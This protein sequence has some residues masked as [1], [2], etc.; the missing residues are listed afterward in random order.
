MVSTDHTAHLK[1]LCQRVSASI[2]LY[3]TGK[4]KKMIL[5][6]AMFSQ[7][8]CSNQL[9]H[10]SHYC[11]AL[12]VRTDL[13]CQCGFSIDDENAEFHWNKRFMKCH[14]TANTTYA[15]LDS[16]MCMSYD[17]TTGVIWGYCPYNS[18]TLRTNHKCIGRGFRYVKIPRNPLLINNV[19]CGEINRTGVLCSE[20]MD[21]LSPAVFHYGM[22]CVT[23]LGYTRGWLLYLLLAFLPS[24]FF[25]LL[26]TALQIHVSSSAL[27]SMVLICQIFI[28]YVNWAPARYIV[29]AEPIHSLQ[30]FLLTV[31]GI[32]NLDFFRYLIPPFCINED[33]TALQTV[34]L[35]YLV[36]VYPLLL[37]KVTYILIELHDRDCRV[38]VLMWRP[39]HRCFTH[40]RRQWNPKATIIHAFASFLLL[41]YIKLAVIS[42][43]LLRNNVMRNETLDEVSRSVAY[44]NPSMELFSS[45]HAPYAV[46]SLSILLIFTFLPLVILV[47]YP[48]TLTQRCLS[49]LHVKLYFLREVICSLQGCFKDGTGQAGGRDLRHFASI[50]LSLRISYVVMLVIPSSAGVVVCLSITCVLAF[51]V[52][53]LKPYKEDWCNIWSSIVLTAI[54]ITTGLF[55]FSFAVPA[56]F[57][58]LNIIFCLPLLYMILLVLAVA[59]KKTHLTQKLK[60]IYQ[61]AICDPGTSTSDSEESLPYRLINMESQ[62]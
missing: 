55:S 48:L 35:E 41:S 47:L 18:C 61:R 5:V 36:A 17:E 39:F 37:I 54:V 21:G 50:F 60:Y 49:A 56:S 59:A 28:N 19:M 22:P 42:C 6:L 58:I 32:W 33:L 25:F 57:I 20:C 62:L 10:S 9:H 27:D 43:T 26:L 1:N 7:A 29:E 23:C 38:L 15:S 40:F 16:A 3:L 44:V 12:F 11:P 14:F 31:Y 24:T 2:S 45:G 52:I 8:Y 34:S 4:M 53:Y 13:G 51:S 30:I 46:L